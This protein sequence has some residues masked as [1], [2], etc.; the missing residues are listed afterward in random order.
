MITQNLRN[1]LF[2]IKI[3]PHTFFMAGVEVI[4]F[5]C[6]VNLFWTFSSA[7]LSFPDILWSPQ[8]FQHLQGLCNMCDTQNLNF[9]CVYKKGTILCYRIW[10]LKTK[11]NKQDEEGI[12]TTEKRKPTDS[13]ISWQKY[14]SGCIPSDVKVPVLPSTLACELILLLFFFLFFSI[15][16]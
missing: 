10:E 14:F 7:A 5:E 13:S 15:F 2:K 8:I 12:N 4:S 16:Y 6:S 3:N 9:L 11:Q 1:I